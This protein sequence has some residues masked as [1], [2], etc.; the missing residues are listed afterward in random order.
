MRR[1]AALALVSACFSKPPFFGGNDDG[2]PRDTSGDDDDASLIDARMI[3][4]RML[5]APTDTPGEP[6]GGDPPCPTI[7]DN[8]DVST[9]GPCAWGVRLSTGSTVAT[10]GRLELSVSAMAGGDPAG[11]A[12][13]NGMPFDRGLWAQL[14][15]ELQTNDQLY[16]DLWVG[17]AMVSLQLIATTSPNGLMKLV[18]VPGVNNGVPT[19]INPMWQWWK[20][21]RQG[22][23]NF[24]SVLRST[25]GVNWVTD[26]ANVNFGSVSLATV[27]FAIRSETSNAAFHTSARVDNLNSPC[28]P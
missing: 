4:A 3:D 27:N 22:A 6:P 9:Q 13:Q 28:T 19:P 21:E 23:T 2:G 1:I 10:N 18:T 17:S 16:F 12:Y 8:F 15:P 7:T 11:C 5:D 20:F 25:D 14:M 24:L 26:T